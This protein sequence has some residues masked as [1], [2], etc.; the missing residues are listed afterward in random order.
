MLEPA[1]NQNSVL[2]ATP[3]CHADNQARQLA[4]FLYETLAT[5]LNKIIW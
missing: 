2:L 4:Q 5:I 1:S 3:A